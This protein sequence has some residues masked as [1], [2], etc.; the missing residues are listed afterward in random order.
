MTNFE[1]TAER[2][3]LRDLAAVG[4]IE[5]VDHA[6][7]AA[8]V[9]ATIGPELFAVVRRALLAPDARATLRPR[10]VA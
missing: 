6:P 3:L 4:R 1:L 5:R 9:E 8:R 2:R 10:R 7:A